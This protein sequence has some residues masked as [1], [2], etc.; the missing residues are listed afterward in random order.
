M[1][2]TDVSFSAPESQPDARFREIDYRCKGSEDSGWEIFRNSVPFMTLPCGY[3]LLETRYCGIC[4]TDLERHNLSFPLPQVTGHEV[5][6]IDNGRAVV[7][8]INA[9]HLSRGLPA[10][11]CP[12]CTSG[13]ASHCPERLTLGIDRLPG[14]FAPFILAPVKGIYVI[15][16][17]IAGPAATLIEPFAAACRA[18]EM[19]EPGSGDSVAVVGPRRLGALLIAAL[20]TF[21]EENSLNFT[22]TAL[23]RHDQVAENALQL[24]ADAVIDVRRKGTQPGLDAFDIV[25][26]TSGTPSGFELAL[27]R[28]ARVVHLK[29]THGLQAAGL[30]HSTEMVINEM[31]IRPPFKDGESGKPGASGDRSSKIAKYIC[32]GSGS[33]DPSPATVDTIQTDSLACIDRIL[34]GDE[35]ISLRPGGSFIYDGNES[36]LLAQAV[37]GRSLQIE[38]SRCGNFPRAVKLLEG[39]RERFE[40]IS[41]LLVTATYPASRINA[42]FE[43]VRT[44]RSMIKAVIETEK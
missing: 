15:P 9:S 23:A 14:G 6:A 28:S 30:A 16:E 42:A 10:D 34:S 44:D 3:R 8:D 39:H 13:L 25:F 38:T 31:S 21:R 4:S 36:S 24:G 35:R 17:W 20:A 26:D 29:S 43:A 11:H 33:G 18:L 5:V 7:V 27:S 32:S 40:T 19:T 37:S 1:K 41:R 12:Y 22:I 2:T